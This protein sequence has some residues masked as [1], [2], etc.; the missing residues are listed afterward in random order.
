MYVGITL[1]EMQVYAMIKAMLHRCLDNGTLSEQEAELLMGEIMHGRL[2]DSQIA[3]FMTLLRFRGETTD[4]LVGFARAMRGMAEPF[5]IHLERTI[6]TCGTGG[7]GL[8]TFNISTATAIVLGS[9]N[10]PVTKHGN[11]S[12]SSKTG[13]ADVFEALNID[14]QTS[15]TEAANMLTEQSLCFMFAPL[16]HP[17]M[18]HVMK[19]RK[20]LGF[21]SIFNL[22]G[23]LTNPAGAKHQ[24]V[25]VN[26]R[27]TA[28]QFGHVLQRLGTTHSVVVSGADGLDECA[29]H[30]ETYLVDVKQD[31]IHANTIKPEDVGFTRSS[32]ASIRVQTPAESAALIHQVLRNEAPQAATNIVAFNAGVALY[33]GDYVSSIQVGVEEA[34]RAIENGHSQ[35]YLTSLQSKKRG[36]KHA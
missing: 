12:V 19:T 32:L 10:I 28:D 17:S 25:G 15:V 9:M 7:D 34:R 26:S 23:P 6:D 16:Y 1:S 29:I 30:G 5:P 14:I 8:G 21:R 4:E 27:A 36:I 20:E 22:L 31:E 11:R 3:S 2:A 13:S 33:A 18:K 24:L 35:L